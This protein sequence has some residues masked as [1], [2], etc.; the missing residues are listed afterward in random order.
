MTISEDEYRE[1]VLFN[2]NCG[3]E[4][5][6]AAELHDRPLA[7]CGGGPSLDIEELRLW[8]GDIWA[9]NNVWKE[10]K[11]AG[12]ESRFYTIDPADSSSLCEGAIKPLLSFCCHPNTFKVVTDSVCFHTEK[13]T[14]EEEF[15]C[16][17]GVTSA[18]RA[19][20]IAHK[21]G[22]KT[23]HFFG[24]DSSFQSAAEYSPITRK[25]LTSCIK[26]RCG[27]KDF[28]STGGM[29]MQAESISAIIREFPTVY[30]SKSTGLMNEMIK[31]PE[32]EL[33]K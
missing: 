9:V 1:R 19:P 16:Y 20:L 33:V 4:N 24:C 10:L 2:L 28:L 18:S 12:I 23:I 31:T 17:G 26:V 30:F 14:G 27:G 13:L 6:S 5:I 15:V 21:L 8:P 3:Y 7:I 29:I 25:S 11:D 22:Y 32:W